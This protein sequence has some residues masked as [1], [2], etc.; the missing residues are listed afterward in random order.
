MKL[1]KSRKGLTLIELLIVVLILG[2]LAAIAIP[3][4][5]QN[6]ATAKLRACQTNIATMN[7]QIEAYH[8]DTDDWPVFATLTTDPCY[9]P[10][11]TPVC[12]SGGTYSMDPNTYRVNCDASGH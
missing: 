2:A 9:F 4:M 11:S 10:D 5:S 1:S 6:S 8:A 7:T 12:P 3:R